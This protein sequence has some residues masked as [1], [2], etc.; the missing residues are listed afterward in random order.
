MA[1]EQHVQTVEL[2]VYC[3]GLYA[4]PPAE[5]IDQTAF[6]AIYIINLNF[7]VFGIVVQSVCKMKRHSVILWC[8][9]VPPTGR[10]R[11]IAVRVI[12]AGKVVFHRKQRSIKGTVKRTL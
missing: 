7:V 9:D 6:R 2:G 11:G 1:F 8:S 10:V 3:N 12:R 4:V 5:R